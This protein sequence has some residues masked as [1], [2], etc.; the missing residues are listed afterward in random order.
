METAREQVQRLVMTVIQ[1]MEMD[2]DL[3]VL[4]SQALFE[5]EDQYHLQIRVQHALPDYKEYG[6]GTY[7]TK[8]GDKY[9]GQ[10]DDWKGKGEIKYKN[11]K[12]YTGHWNGGYSNNFK[13]HELGIL[14]SADGQVLNQG[15][16]GKV[17][18]VGKE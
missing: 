12:K 14:Y 16:W 17:Q 4:S 7:Y 10:W 11:G 5:V 1:T 9:T 3:Y 18:Y 6:Q 8:N 13:R 2:A 15:K